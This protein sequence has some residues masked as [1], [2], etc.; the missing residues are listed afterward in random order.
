MKKPVRPT[1]RVAWCAGVAGMCTSL[2]FNDLRALA[3]FGLA[4][5]ACVALAAL[6]DTV[7]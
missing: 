5:V 1:L 2:M 3:L 7:L 4:V 6:E